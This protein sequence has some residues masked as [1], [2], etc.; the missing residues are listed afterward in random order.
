[1]PET[2]GE[3][4]S[5]HGREDWFGHLEKTTR[6]DIADGGQPRG[7]VDG[8]QK[9]LAAHRRPAGHHLEGGSCRW[10]ILRDFLRHLDL[11]PEK[12]A[13]LPHLRADPERTFVNLLRLNQRRL[14]ERIVSRVVYKSKDLLD[15]P[16]DHD[17]PFDRAY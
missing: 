10:L 6:L 12:S 7:A 11:H 2:G 5:R 14:P 15:R 4:A 8:L 3:L 9:I 13:P 1:M 16:V 17:A